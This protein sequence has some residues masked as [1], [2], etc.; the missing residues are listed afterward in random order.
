MSGFEVV[1][2]A[3]RQQKHLVKNYVSIIQVIYALNSYIKILISKS[4]S[5]L[6]CIALVLSGRVF[7]LL[8][9]YK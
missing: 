5:L 4:D 9:H 3:D 1:L 8:Q 2:L 7:M 6:F